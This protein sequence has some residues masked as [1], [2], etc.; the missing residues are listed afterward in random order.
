MVPP[1]NYKPLKLRFR[2][3]L[4]GHTVATITYFVTKMTT[5]QRVNVLKIEQFFETV[6]VAS[7]DKEWL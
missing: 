6:I 7:S 2:A 3:F 1:L 4:V 5:C